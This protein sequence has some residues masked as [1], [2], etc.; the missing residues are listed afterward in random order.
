[1][2]WYLACPNNPRLALATQPL[3]YQDI[4][5]LMESINRQYILEYLKQS[6]SKPAEL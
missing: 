6:N 2:P 4:H 1:M 3:L 5:H